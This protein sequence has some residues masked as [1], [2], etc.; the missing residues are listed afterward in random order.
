MGYT[1]PSCR[2]LSACLRSGLLTQRM[3]WLHCMDIIYTEG[4]QNLKKTQTLCT[5]PV[6]KGTLRVKPGSQRKKPVIPG[7]VT[8]QY[9]ILS[10]AQEASFFRLRC[11]KTRFSAAFPENPFSTHTNPIFNTYK[12]INPRWLGKTRRA[13]ANPIFNPYEP[14]IQPIKTRK[15]QYGSGKSGFPEVAC[16]N[17]FGGV[18]GQQQKMFKCRVLRKPVFGL[19]NTVLSQSP[20]I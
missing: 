5:K 8:S 3:H 6:F 16:L 4:I 10:P 19:K 15:S 7:N 14:L 11:R 13:R 2:D 1:N 20:I 12:P 17:P 9:F 18:P